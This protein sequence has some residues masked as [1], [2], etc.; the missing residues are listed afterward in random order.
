[1]RSL[2]R[3][4]ATPTRYLVR[5]TLLL[6]GLLGVGYGYFNDNR[7]YLFLGV[8]LIVANVLSS[9]VDMLTGKGRSGSQ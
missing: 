9:V 2:P 6:V 8:L 1:M 7:V 5:A 4:E 3:Y